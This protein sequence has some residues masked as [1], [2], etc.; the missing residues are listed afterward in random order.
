MSAPD[1]NQRAEELVRES[2]KLD[3]KKE[4]EVFYAEPAVRILYSNVFE[5]RKPTSFS[6]PPSN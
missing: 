3:P 5:A 1:Y 6:V 2:Q 4:H